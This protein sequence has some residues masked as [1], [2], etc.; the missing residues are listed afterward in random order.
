MYIC[1]AYSYYKYLLKN[2]KMQF[3]K[4]NIIKKMD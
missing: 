3:K 4:E 2:G 1:P